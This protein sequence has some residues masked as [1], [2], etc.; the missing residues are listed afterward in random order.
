MELDDI[1]KEAASLSPLAHLAT[2]GADGAPDVAPVHPAWEGDT[3]WVMSYSN[4]V[5]VRNLA[6][7]QAVAMH[8]QVS[9]K[10]DGVAVWGSGRVFDDIETKRR[11]W[12]GVFDY[13]L[14]AFA[15][16][17]PATEGVCFVAVEPDRALVLKRYGMAGRDTWRR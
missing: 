4:S 8:W 12:N 7:N 17:G 10:G 11:L 1:K 14:D 6:A 3:L 16:E 5:K 2:V 13:D 15:P 9:E